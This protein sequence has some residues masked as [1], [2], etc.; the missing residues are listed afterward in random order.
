M[1]YVAFGMMALGLML[2]GVGIL[3][4]VMQLPD[5]WRGIISGPVVTFIGVV[6]FVIH[7][8]SK[9]KT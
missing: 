4:E 5:L 9:K 1:K 6:L 2:F 8:L 7:L 3:F